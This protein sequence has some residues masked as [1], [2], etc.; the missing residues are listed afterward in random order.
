MI[1][2]EYDRET[3]DSKRPPTVWV[4]TD[5]KNLMLLEIYDDPVTMQVEK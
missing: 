4:E 5:N 3:A 2:I 1:K